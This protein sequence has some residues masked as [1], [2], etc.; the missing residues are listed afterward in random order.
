MSYKTS[1][2]AIKSILIVEY[3]TESTES[4][5]V[6]KNQHEPNKSQQKSTLV[7]QKWTKTSTNPTRF[8]TN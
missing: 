3:Q 7:T 8:D 1:K 4:S 6:N 2:N 5:Q